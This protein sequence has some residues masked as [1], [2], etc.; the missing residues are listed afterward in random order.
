MKLYDISELIPL[1]VKPK[2][3]LSAWASQ[4]KTEQIGERAYELDALCNLS[5]Y[6]SIGSPIGTIYED[7]QMVHNDGN[8][9]GAGII[10]G[11]LDFGMPWEK[12]WTDY[13]TGY[14]SCIIDGAYVPPSFKD[15]YVFDCSLARIGIGRKQGR[16]Y[17]VTDDYV[18]LK[19]F[20]QHG[21]SMGLDTL[22]NNDGGGSRFLMYEGKVIYGSSRTPYNAM[23]FYK[24]VVCTVP[25]P[26]NYP[27][28]KRNL[29]YGC[30]GEDVKWLQD[31]LIKHGYNLSWIDGIFGPNTWRETVAY[32]KTWT[33]WPDGICGP[34]TRAHLLGE[35]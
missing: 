32:Q 31:Q 22:V 34:N 16:A 10:G 4:H 28:P 30:R 14:T 19:Q 15:N 17:I 33:K 24:S 13:Y 21:L 25:S 2:M 5:L 20:A 35:K 11:Y 3:N 8:G 18:T 27:V 7:G 23:A 6:T 29:F 26:S 12:A 1:Y 9:Y